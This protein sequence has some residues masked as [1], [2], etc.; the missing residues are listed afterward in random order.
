MLIDEMF[1]LMEDWDDDE[2]HQRALD[3]T[4]FWGDQA[5]GSLIMSHTTDRFLIA[6]RSLHVKEPG[7]WG[8]WGGAIDK[9]EDPE[10]AARR[11]IKEE[12]GYVG[13]FTMLPMY[14]FVSDTGFR[15][16]NFLVVVK[17]EFKPQLNWETQGFRWCQWGQWPTPLHFGLVAVL[18]DP[19]SVATIKKARSQ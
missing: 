8:T 14:V 2:R 13:L 3:K 5:A 16:S 9:G 1:L 15:Y 19:A 18:N 12:T 11:E 7:T 10:V 4:G 6:H 17:D